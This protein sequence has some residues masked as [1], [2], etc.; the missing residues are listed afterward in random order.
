[1]N[2]L[3]LTP[4]DTLFFR[5][6]RPMNGALA[7]HGA[8]WPLPTVTNAALHA[9][10][11]D[12]ARAAQLIGVS[13]HHDH[14][15]GTSRH[16]KDVR[17]FGSLTSAGPFPVGTKD[18]VP[19]WCFPRPLDLTGGTLAPTL[20]PRLA[21]GSSSL[22]LPLKATLVTTLPPSKTSP[23]KAWLSAADYTTYLTG[24]DTA[25]AKSPAAAFD[26]EDIYLDESSIG[27]ALDP[28]TGTTGQ[29]EAQGKIYSAHSLRLR[30]NWHLG[31]LAETDEE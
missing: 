9:A 13:H 4:T 25:L 7:G 21:T 16:L 6:G 15:R 12:A 1:M 31:L 19:V 23:A 11:H 5:D 3:L 29:G 30:P 14:K 27:I 17:A 24:D 28:A 10:L 22:P 20:S 18:N 26:D 8:A 2:Q